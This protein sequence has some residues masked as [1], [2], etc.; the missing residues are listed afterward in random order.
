[1]LSFVA[2]RIS[3]RFAKARQF[4]G[5]SLD[6]KAASASNKKSLYD[7]LAVKHG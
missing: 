4:P 7:V 3:K 5:A 2:G 6:G 1:V